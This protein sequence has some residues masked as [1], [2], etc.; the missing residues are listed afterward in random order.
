[1]M[2]TLRPKCNAAAAGGRI[3]GIVA[4]PCGGRNA[5]RAADVASTPAAATERQRAMIPLWLHV[6]ALVMVIAGLGCAILIALDELRRPQPM[7][8]MNAV[9]PVTALFGT[10]IALAA[11]LAYGRPRPGDEHDDSRHP[12]PVSVGIGAAHCGS[13]CALGDLIAEW[14]AYL[15]PAVA[16]A[17]GWQS[18]FADKMFAVWILDF[19]LAFGFGIVFQYFSIVPMRKLSPAAGIVAALKADALSLTAWQIGM[20]AFM[21]FAQ[22]YLF[23]RLL[24]APLAVDSVEFWFMMQIAMLCGFVTSYPVNWWLIRTGIKEEM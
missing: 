19:I 10:F 23:R 3:A 5:A 9:W 2:S 12:F 4:G 6:L 18:L 1:M 21:A 13:G 20:Y 16:V 11:Y 7:A 24:G 14:L 22:F 8:I 17:F 15:A